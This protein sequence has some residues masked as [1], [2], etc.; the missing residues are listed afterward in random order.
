ML[1]LEKKVKEAGITVMNEIVLIRGSAIFTLS[2][3]LKKFIELAARSPP[4]CPTAVDSQLQKL[5]II[6]LATSFHGQVVVSY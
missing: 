3:Q 2:R 5:Q 4:F 1:E 6:H